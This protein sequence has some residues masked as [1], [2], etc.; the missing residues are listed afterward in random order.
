MICLQVY[1]QTACASCARSRA[2]AREIAQEFHQVQVEII[3]VETL[4][5]EDWPDALFA[6][7]TWLWN[8]RRYCLGTPDP[9]RLRGAIIRSLSQ[10]SFPS[11]PKGLS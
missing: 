1:V 5:A 9:D 10:S 8:G 2:L 7:P 6:A 4:A 11:P 3:E